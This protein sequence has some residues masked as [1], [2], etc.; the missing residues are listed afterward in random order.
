[1]TEPPRHATNCPTDLLHCPVAVL[2][3][4]LLARRLALGPLGPRA[5]GAVPVA[6]GVAAPLLDDDVIAVPPALLLHLLVT[7]PR[8]HVPVSYLHSQKINPS[9][10]SL[11]NVVVV[12]IFFQSLSQYQGHA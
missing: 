6:A 3:P 8:A 11:T 9:R 2:D 10:T 1:M 4:R 7:V 12:V 5:H